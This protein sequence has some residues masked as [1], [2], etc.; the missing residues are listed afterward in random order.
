MPMARPPEEDIYQE[1]FK[2]KYTSHYL[3]EYIDRHA[4]AGQTLRE[5][6]TFGIGVRTIFKDKGQWMISGMNRTGDTSTFKSPKLIIASGLTSIPKM[7]NLPRQETFQNPV[8]HQKDFAKSKILSRD[9]LKRITVLGGAKSAAH[10]AYDCVKAGKTVTWI[11]RATGTGPGFFVTIDS[12]ISP[13]TTYQLGTT[14]MLSTLSPSLFNPSS[15]WSLFLQ[16]TQFGRKQLMGFWDSLHKTVVEAPKFDSRG[17]E[18]K[19]NG[20]AELKPH[21]PVFWQNQGA[22]L[23]NRADFWD[24]I[25]QNVQV[26]HADIEELTGGAIVLKDGSTVPADAILCGTGWVPSLDFFDQATLAELGIPQPLENYPSDQAE[27][28]NA[29]EKEADTTVLDRFPLLGSPP[30]HYHTPVKHTP[31]RL[32]NGIAPLQDKSIAFVGHVLVPNYFRV[33]ECQAIWTTAYLDNKINLP[34]LEQR[35][36]EVAMFVAWC[37]RRYLSNGDRGHWMA[38]EQT[39]YTDRL[40][41]QI[42]LSSHR[43]F[44]LWDA[45]FP[46]SKKDLHRVRAEYMKKFGRDSEVMTEKR[47]VCD[48]PTSSHHSYPPT[49]CTYTSSTQSWRHTYLLSR[50]L[51]VLSYR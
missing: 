31:Y 43:R 38:G 13:R 37:R 39:R 30:E 20:F 4:W 51:K 47:I 6:I 14:R 44:W 34:P 45:F 11:I 7:P 25:A 12:K 26:H 42:G 16:H 8:I 9:D 32:Y 46:S 3:E 29:L 1:S 18:A 22:G 36:N 23:V 28:W 49:Q 41:H 15:W 19:Q 35:R 27:M 2:A 40:F 24:T 50:T 10:L 21:T 17:P 33:A 48:T 5:R